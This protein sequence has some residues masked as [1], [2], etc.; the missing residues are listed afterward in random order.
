[1][2]F[3]LGSLIQLAAII[4]CIEVTPRG[5]DESIRSHRP[6]LEATDLNSIPRLPARCWCRLASSGTR[7]RQ[8]VRG[9]VNPHDQVIHDHLQI[10]EIG[11]E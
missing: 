10:R 5:G 3:Y 1:M 8:L 9:T 4:G 6:H 2:V 7:H 11:H